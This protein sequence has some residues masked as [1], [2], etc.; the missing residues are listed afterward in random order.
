MKR[1]REYARQQDEGGPLRLED[2]SGKSVV[3]TA[4]KWNE[5]DFGQY[6]LMA[7]T[8]PSGESVEVLTGA[9]LV[10]D[11]LHNAEAMAAFPC[12]VLFL[13]RGRTW[14]IDD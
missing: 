10:V 3:I 12:E 1:L 5:G 6:A 8:L 9:T 2:V 7:I 14:I 11:A 4:V 13:K